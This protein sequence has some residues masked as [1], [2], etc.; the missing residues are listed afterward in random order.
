MRILVAFSGQTRVPGC[1]TRSP[2]LYTGQLGHVTDCWRR[3][4]L[5]VEIRR[6]FCRDRRRSKLWDLF[7]IFAIATPA[8]SVR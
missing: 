8:A 4:G 3:T 7:T 5:V 2:A 6:S 1:W